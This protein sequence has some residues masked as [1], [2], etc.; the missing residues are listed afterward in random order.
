MPT[1]DEFKL[2]GLDEK[3]IIKG[4]KEDT[5]EWA[6]FF[7]YE[8]E[9]QQGLFKAF[10]IWVLVLLTFLGILVGLTFGDTIL[11]LVKIAF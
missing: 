10:A 3:M 6:E 4:T 7:A 5:N 1:D 9:K 11:E 8:R 2:E